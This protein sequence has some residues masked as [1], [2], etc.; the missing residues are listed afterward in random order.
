MREHL[1]ILRNCKYLIL[2]DK[3]IFTTYDKRK[4]NES[5]LHLVKTDENNEWYMKADLEHTWN[6]F[7]NQNKSSNL[8]LWQVINYLL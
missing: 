3:S 4:F 1:H 8:C 5:L 6:Q 7:N 2:L